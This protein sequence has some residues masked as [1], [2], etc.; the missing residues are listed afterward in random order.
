[1]FKK[2]CNTGKILEEWEKF[3][4]SSFFKK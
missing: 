2:P 3:Y 1:M 4:M